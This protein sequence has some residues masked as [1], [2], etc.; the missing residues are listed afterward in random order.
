MEHLADHNPT[1]EF[2]IVSNL[3]SIVEA[4]GRAPEHPW[5]MLPMQISKRVFLFVIVINSLVAIG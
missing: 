3:P 2:R 5:G 1:K 4:R